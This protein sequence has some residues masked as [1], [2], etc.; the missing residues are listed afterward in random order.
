MIP[1]SQRSH[2][3][4]TRK[5]AF[6]RTPRMLRLAAF[7]ATI[8]VAT[9][10][11][12]QQQGNG[13]THILATYRC[14][15]ADRPQLRQELQRRAVPRFEAM[16]RDGVIND[17]A[18]LMS[19]FVNGESWDL[20]TVVSFDRYTNIERWETLSKTTPGG[21]APEVARIVD[22]IH[23]YIADLTWGKRDL[24]AATPGA[25][26]LVQEKEFENWANRPNYHNYMNAREVPF[27]EA[28][29]KHKVASSYQVYENQH[30]NGEPWDTMH[31]LRFA[32]LDDY[33]RR[34]EGFERARASLA[35]NARYRV[36]ES[37]RVQNTEAQRPVLADAITGEVP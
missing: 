32:S 25:V 22:P 30:Y 7:A 35:D 11:E 9:T 28:V 36:F 13:P 3:S 10:A 37:N 17:Y 33:M 8:F 20:L 5:V 18:V 27:Y 31:I 24:W 14:R 29:L 23:E 16:K 6:V 34:R 2:F 12:A 19:S 21:L 4:P 26:Y 1:H 15:P